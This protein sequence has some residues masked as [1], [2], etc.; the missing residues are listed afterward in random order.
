[1]REGATGLDRAMAVTGVGLSHVGETFTSFSVN[2]GQAGTVAPI[3]MV[4]GVAPVLTTAAPELM[5]VGGLF[6]GRHLLNKAVSGEPITNQDVVDTAMLGF[7]AWGSF[8]RPAMVRPQAATSVTLTADTAGGASFYVKPDGTTIPGTAYRTVGGPAVG[9]AYSG[10]VTPRPGG[11]YFTFDD[12][13]AMPS[14][15]AKSF[16]QLYREPSHVLTFDT[17]QVLDD[18]S[19]PKMHW[20]KG[21]FDEPIVDVFPDLGVGGATQA[22]TNAPIRPLQV[23]P[24][25]EALPEGPR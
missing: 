18:V 7:G 3:A 9:E 12:I 11:T 22:I 4:P 2:A 15:E 10:L 25:P 8:G 6:Q 5:T 1:M 21:L 14:A 24:L 16:L 19:I 17:I 13:S 20:G 23:K